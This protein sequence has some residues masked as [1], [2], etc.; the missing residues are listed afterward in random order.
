MGGA[1]PASPPARLRLDLARTGLGP[2]GL[3]RTVEWLT[4]VCGWAL[5]L[6]GNPL[7]APE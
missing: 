2:A 5:G 4:P 3:R 7:P 1:P 6:E